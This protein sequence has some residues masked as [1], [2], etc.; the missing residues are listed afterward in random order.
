[1]KDN[2]LNPEK[3]A[4]NNSSIE[5]GVEVTKGSSREVIY[6]NDR[7]QNPDEQLE[8]LDCFESTRVKEEHEN[9]LFRIFIKNGEYAFARPKDIVMI[10]SCN[11]FINVYLANGNK[12]KKGIRNNTLKDFFKELPKREFV[13]ISRFCVV[14]STRLSGCNY[15][16]QILEFD[17]RIAVKPKRSFS[18]T[19]FN[20]LGR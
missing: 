17:F 15:N 16:E 19:V 8:H 1:M 4:L 6:F 3:F 12:I 14:N 9:N 20:T 11:H 7:I 10:E 2:S 13:R 5:A 18:K